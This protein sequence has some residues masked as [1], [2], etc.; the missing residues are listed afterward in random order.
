MPEVMLL[1]LDVDCITLTS[2]EFIEMSALQQSTQ[3][4]NWYNS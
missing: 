2:T 4:K 3:E 1:K